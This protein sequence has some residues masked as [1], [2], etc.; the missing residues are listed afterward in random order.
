[1]GAARP[2]QPLLEAGLCDWLHADNTC[3]ASGWSSSSARGEFPKRTCV[4]GAS[5]MHWE[6]VCL[7]QE[8]RPVRVRV[9][10]IWLWRDRPALSPK[11]N[12]R[13]RAALLQRQSQ[14]LGKETTLRQM[15]TDNELLSARSFLCSL[16]KGQLMSCRRPRS[17]SPMSSSELQPVICGGLLYPQVL[18]WL[19]RGRHLH[20]PGRSLLRVTQS[21][22]QA[23]LSPPPKPP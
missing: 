18:C 7:S 9:W 15:R 16:L 22:A 23:A 4:L 17:T 19:P 8:Q 13:D 2:V 20:L 12:R 10:D 1:M 11:P 14:A 21:A 3:Y 5:L 6:T